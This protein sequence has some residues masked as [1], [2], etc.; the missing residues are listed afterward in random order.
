M[1]PPEEGGVSCWP[2]A[3]QYLLKN[4]AQNQHISAAISE[5]RGTRQTESED[6][7]HF[8]VRLNQ[9]MHKCGNVHSQLEVITL[10]SLIHI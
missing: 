1:V 6:E 4:Y 9:A 7:R 3:V 2:E 5:L 8:S 10:L